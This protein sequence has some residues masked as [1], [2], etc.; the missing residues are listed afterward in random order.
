MS[1]LTPATEPAP[2]SR[3]RAGLRRLTALALGLA[4]IYFGSKKLG[5]PAGF[6]KAIHEYDSLAN[7]HFA[8][9]NILATWIP[10]LEIT[11]GIL[12]FP[13]IL[14]R[15]AALVLLLILLGFT[16]AVLFQT[17]YLQET[18]G[19]SF[20]DIAFDCGCGTGVVHACTKLL[21]NTLMILACAWIAW[22]P[23]PQKV[24]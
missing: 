20:C 2:G 17:L 16:T 9:L 7:L 6:L 8:F 22:T 12:L 19:K 1:E 15:G 24:R 4:M 21:Q 11:G 3:A 10:I 18:L 14:R 13:G 23:E 5:D